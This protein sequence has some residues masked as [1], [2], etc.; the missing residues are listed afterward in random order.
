[1]GMGCGI[2][3]A[4]D[5]VGAAKEPHSSDGVGV[6]VG[7]GAGVIVAVEVAEDCAGCASVSRITGSDSLSPPDGVGFVE[8]SDGVN[9]V[10]ADKN[11][12]A[13][14]NDPAK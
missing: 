6:K 7:L 1:M 2:S 9:I 11:I 4:D 10:H 8:H 14:S 12:P 13:V 5:A 3:V